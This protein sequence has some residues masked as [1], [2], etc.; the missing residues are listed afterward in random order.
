MNR[1]GLLLIAMLLSNPVWAFRCGHSLV[2]I[3]DYK[4]DVLEKCGEP[5]A[6]EER[7]AVRGSRLRHPYGALQIDNYEEILIEE[8]VYNFGPR[9][10]KQFLHFE[11]GV[12]TSIRKLGYG[13]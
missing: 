2:K 7:M 8:W 10:F 9:Q 11:D 6:L 13:F 12:L 3:G 4:F 1:V 5:D